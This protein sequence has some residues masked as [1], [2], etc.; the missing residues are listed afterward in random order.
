MGTGA[1]HADRRRA[2]RLRELPGPQD[3]PRLLWAKGQDQRSDSLE[4]VALLP[5][6]EFLLPEPLSDA[7]RGPGAKSR[8]VHRP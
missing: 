8:L 2:Q 6:V 1:V 5:V 4:G 7:C 3:D